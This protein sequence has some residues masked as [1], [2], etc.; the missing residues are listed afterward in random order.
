MNSKLLSNPS[1]C[2]KAMAGAAGG[3]GKSGACADGG[4]GDGEE[5]FL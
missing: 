1:H 5:L 3:R 2:R 4:C